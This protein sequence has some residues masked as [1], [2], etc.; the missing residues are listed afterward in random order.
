MFAVVCGVRCCVSFAEADIMR[1]VDEI[2]RE[3]EE[4]EEAD[5]KEKSADN[6]NL[7]KPLQI[8]VSKEAGDVSM[9]LAVSNMEVGPFFMHLCTLL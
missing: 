6:N 8:R 5:E 7:L 3:E 1:K 4:A 9:S 2:K